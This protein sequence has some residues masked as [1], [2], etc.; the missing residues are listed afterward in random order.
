MN[1]ALA[2]LVGLLLL[3][4][5]CAWA[6]AQ[7][8]NSNTGFET[9]VNGSA[10][11]WSPYWQGYVV[12]S[13]VRHSGVNSIKCVNT[14]TT[15]RRGAFVLIT[16]N[17][18]T[19]TPLS[20]T[21]WS[22]ASGVS[23]S[24]DS[25]YSI[26]ASM[27][28]TDG[29]TADK[30]TPFATG[31]HDWQSVEVKLTPT[32]PVRSVKLHVLLNRHLGTVWFDDVV[33]V[34]LANRVF[35]N[36]TL[37]IPQLPSGSTSG[38]FVRDV[39][40]NSDV[41]PLLTDT[42]V[43]GSAAQQLHLQLT[44]VQTDPTGQIVQAR[45]ADTSGKTR[46]VTLYYVEKFT[47]ANLLWWNDNRSSTLAGGECTNLT[48]LFGRISNIGATGTMSLYPFGC[49]TSST[50]GRAVGVP[51]L[52]G[53]RI[54]RI[55]YNS[56]GSL[57]YVA[58]DLAL[59]ST[60]AFNS[61][62]AGHG[63]AD[64]GIVR[65]AVD[66]S[67]G[68]R[69]A[70]ATYYRLFPSAFQRRTNV[71]GIWL[72]YADPSTITNPQDFGFGYHDNNKALAID[73][74]LGILNFNYSEPQTYWMPMASTTPRTYSAALNQ[75]QQDL[76][77]TDPIKKEW[78]QA[79]FNSGT[80]NL[81]GLF[82]V[83]FQN[84]TWCNGAV[85]ILNPNPYIPY[86]PGQWTK[87]RIMYSPEIANQRYSTTQTLT[88][89]GEFLDSL[90]GYTSFTATD[91]NPVSLQ[92][93]KVPATFT[94]DTRRAVLPI[95]FGVYEMAAYMSNDLHQRGKVLM[96]NGTPWFTPNFLPLLDTAAGEVTWLING[97]YTPDTDAL[98]NYR[99]T[100]A[101]HKPYHLAQETDFTAFG[102]YV[103]RYFQRCMFYGIYPSFY[104]PQQASNYWTTPT[105]YNRDRPLF[106]KYIPVIRSLSAAGW[107]PITYARSSN[108]AVYVER[109][110]GTY[111]TVMND[112][113]TAAT[114]T[115]AIDFTRFPLAFTASSVKVVN[116]LTGAV[117]AT[118]PTTGTAS[119]TLTLNAGQTQVLQLTP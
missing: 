1:R 97:V 35:D 74:T 53:P 111:L 19:A 85:W 106:V 14:A 99:R 94:R 96:A 104:A 87:A 12:D 72:P 3:M 92:Y 44:N 39:A 71:E 9:V 59:Q 25:F 83:F 62:G 98:F 31:T 91:F 105:L 43:V 69:S 107:E 95:W 26:Y 73:K 5:P 41:L 10:S 116:K 76:A 56:Y 86:T 32:K 100:L 27:T 60:S 117:L 24:A 115:L 78:A 54:T 55:G 61:D 108:P 49:V 114:T 46:A 6:Q 112:S 15:D 45:L 103:E 64:V 70:S 51:P 110:G 109:F 30:Y 77:G 52:L 28:Y 90:E 18:T 84:Q 113:N 38:W 58:F 2:A 119:L 8:L 37:T 11:G 101:Y 81:S 89:D 57:L 79:V 21:G 13:T 75:I 34:S 65:Y 23:G 4:T 16:L 17:Q 22:K 48:N 66:P 93:A 20:I 29:T 42:G 40:A 102:P 47:G 7:A 118:V 63:F 88:F 36:Q 80:K 67:W 68:F 50:S 82:N 33:M